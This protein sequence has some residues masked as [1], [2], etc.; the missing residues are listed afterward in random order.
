MWAGA[1]CAGFAAQHDYGLDGGRPALGSKTW[2]DPAGLPIPTGPAT[3]IMFAHPRCPW[4]GASIAGPRRRQ[5]ACGDRLRV[6]VA[7]WRPDDSWVQT[8]CWRRTVEASPRL[9]GAHT[10]GQ[11]FVDDRERRLVL[12]GGITPAKGHEGD[13]PGRR[14]V[15][16]LA[17][18][19]GGP[20]VTTTPVY[21]CALDAPGAR[22]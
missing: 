9:F 3:L 20:D 16:A 6:H 5:A 18:G 11:V 14:T 10:S 21:R 19:S 13:S 4:T 2:P 15:L 8:D 12:N 17:H 22:R 1:V 7:S